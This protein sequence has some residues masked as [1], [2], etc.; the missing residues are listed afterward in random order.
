MKTIQSALFSKV[1]PL[2]KSIFSDGMKLDLFSK[3]EATQLERIDQLEERSELQDIIELKD[4]EK[5]ELGF[6][7]Q[8]K[9]TKKSNL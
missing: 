1:F 5:A 4:G 6:A 9:P 7:I 8:Q 3:T 2:G